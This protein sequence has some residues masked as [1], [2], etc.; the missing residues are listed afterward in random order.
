MVEIRA[1]PRIHLSLID[2]AN[3]T[4]RR[5]GGAGFMLDGMPVVVQYAGSGPLSINVDT[6]LDETAYSDLV[7]LKQRISKLCPEARGLIVVKSVPY[8]HVGFG[9]KTALLLAIIKCVDIVNDLHWSRPVMQ[10]LSGRGG[11]S[12]VGI[13]G[14]FIGGLVVDGGHPGLSQTYRPSSSTTP[15]MIPPVLIR[16]EFPDIWRV[17]LVMPLGKII[18]GKIESTFFR[19]NTPILASAALESLAAVYHGVVVAFVQRDIML[20]RDAIELL[21]MTGFKALEIRAQ[22]TN[23]ATVL[24]KLR[25][26]LDYP[27]GLSSLGPLIYVISP[28][29]DT[30]V[31]QVI[32]TKSIESGAKYLGCFKGRNSSYEVVN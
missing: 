8:Q 9:T 7:N 24:N 12:G 17:H 15:Q 25:H 16:L 6:D 4:L 32:H 22:S 18:S 27:V 21:S 2:L 1:Y 10:Q 20:L 28:A 11:A 26:N 5:Y 29:T 31:E 3:A 30:T 19:E 23:T 14:F 13:N